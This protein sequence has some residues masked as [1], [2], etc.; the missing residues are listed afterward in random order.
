VVINARR[1]NIL[2]MA[3]RLNSKSA[4]VY[5]IITRYDDMYCI[6]GDSFN[7]S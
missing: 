6:Q 3:V 1:Y 5:N 7:G 2:Y 4:A